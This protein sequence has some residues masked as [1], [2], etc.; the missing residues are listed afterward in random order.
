[1]YMASLTYCDGC[2]LLISSQDPDLDVGFSQ[3]FNAL[4]NIL[5]GRVENS[6]LG[7]DPNSC[8][9]CLKLVINGCGPQKTKVLHRHGNLKT[10]KSNKKVSHSS[11]LSDG[12]GGSDGGDG[13]DGSSDGGG[14]GD[15]GGD[16]VVMWW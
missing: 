14:G 6:P 7:N 9:H 15:G 11:Y 3:S 12:G 4:W 13:G 1:M 2:L 16:V 5:R 8:S 10:N